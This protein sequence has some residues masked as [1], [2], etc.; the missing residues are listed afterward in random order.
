METLFPASGM[1]NLTA[2]SSLGLVLF[3][4]VVGL[5]FD[6]GMIRNRAPLAIVVSQYSIAVPLLLG[7]LLAFGLYPSFATAD[8]SFPAFA[9][10]MGASMSV[11][12]F[13]VLARILSERGLVRT[14]IGALTLTCAAINDVT[15]WCMLA[16]TIAVV[17]S[18]GLLDSV[19]TTVLA[20][21]F[22][23]VMVGA[24]RPFLARVAQR[25]GTIDDLS[26]TA[27]A[28]ILLLLLLSGFASEAIGIHALFGAFLFGAVVPRQGSVIRALTSRIEDLVVVLLMPLFFA[29]TGLRTSIGLVDTPELWAYCILITVFASAGK[30]IGAAVPAWMGGLPL[31]EA[32][33]LGVLMNTRGLMELVILNI[34]RDLGVL[35][36][37]LFTMLVIMAVV[38]TFVIT[39]IVRRLYP[40]ERVLAEEA[41]PV[42][43]QAGFTVIACVS[44]PA[45]A[46]GLGRLTAAFCASPKARAFAVQLLPTEDRAS[47]FPEGFATPPDGVAAT[48]ANH[49]RALGVDVETVTFPSSDPPRDI[50]VVASLKH[51][52]LVL[53]GLHRPL[54]GT[55][56]LGGPLIEVAKGLACDAAMFHDVGFEHARRVLVARG[57]ANDAA[58]MRVAA[59]LVPGA[60]VTEFHAP[61]GVDP[62]DALSD[63]ATAYDLLV[64]GV[65][66]EW[67]LA[68][69]A[70]DVREHR[71]LSRLR[72]SL[73]AVH[74][75]A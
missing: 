14:Q 61:T 8:V 42:R 54:L 1:A 50:C 38:T 71:L 58:V 35:S 49:A 30:L 34:G 57:G 11:T 70:F 65:G 46:A 67:D 45:T 6:L 29:S 18:G 12:A 39:P 7:V 19:R 25:Y 52:D 4:F 47:L 60:T 36:P 24:V 27:I 55:A 13:P 72:C 32:T 5:E 41:E 40:P 31:R 74:G 33:T 51:A 21:V 26:Q 56:H 2:V 16:F 75:A 22:I 62:I 63:A 23:A 20:A 43:P 69:Q 28:A 9:L 10:F 44:H 3:M 59:R 68:M 48:L 64:A 73:L 15:A 17:R 37:L 53:L 66:P